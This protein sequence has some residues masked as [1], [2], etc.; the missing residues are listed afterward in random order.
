MHTEGLGM[1]STAELIIALRTEKGLTQEELAEML[2][3]SRSLVSMW[4]L[5]TRIPDYSNV[6]GLAKL[7]NLKEAD[8]VGGDDHLYCSSTELSKF[9]DELDEFTQQAASIQ[10]ET[11]IEAIVNELLT[12]L[13][14]KDKEI[15]VSR[16]FSAKTHKTIAADL[17]M[18][19]SAVKVRLTR[20]RKKLIKIIRGR[21][22]NE[23]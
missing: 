8:I 3:V 13:T 17:N 22:K 23:Q 19:E 20:I 11:D 1:P 21:I 15:F 12:G 6:V 9:F 10:G 4:E 16:Y 18:T 7:F 14:K 5:G 2:F